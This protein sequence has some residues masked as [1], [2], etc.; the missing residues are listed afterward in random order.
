MKRAHAALDPDLPS[1]VVTGSIAE[2]IGGGVTPEGTTIARFLPRTI[3][4]D[5]WQCAN[6]AMY[7]LWSEYGLRKVPQ[8]TPFAE[9]PGRRE[10]AREPDR[11]LLRHLQ[12]AQR[13]G[14]DPPPGAGHWRRSEHG[15]P[16]GQP[17]GRCLAPGGSRRQHLHVPRI[18]P[19]AVRS[20]G[21]ALPAGPYRPAQ[22]DRVPPATGRI[23]A[24]GPGTVHPAREAHH[25]Q[26]DLGPVAQ[27]HAGLLRH[28]KLRGGGRRD[29]CA[30]HPPL[31]GRRARPALQLRGVAQGGQQDRQRSSA[32][33]SRTRSRR[34]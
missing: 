20:A 10:A 28:R 25:D 7:W 27:R 15:V 32:Q 23:A 13:P 22:H 17:P 9:R 26:A 18:R 4:E 2:M 21:T 19:H 14:R 1:V 6:R 16:A 8:R 5:Q 34:W 29:L 3:D 31:P 12:H 33:A 24:P 30:R 11:P